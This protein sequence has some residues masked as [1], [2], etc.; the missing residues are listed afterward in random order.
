[1]GWEDRTTSKEEQDIGSS[2]WKFDTKG[3]ELLASRGS[4]S[5]KLL[6][7]PAI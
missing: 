2:L 1:M 4:G 3:K 6:R 7:E 5:V